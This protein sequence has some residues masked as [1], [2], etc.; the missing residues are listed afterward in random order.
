MFR[1]LFAVTGILTQKSP[2]RIWSPSGLGQGHCWSGI[3]ERE[4][5]RQMARRVAVATTAPHPGD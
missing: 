3:S 4:M 1:V 5:M 2:I